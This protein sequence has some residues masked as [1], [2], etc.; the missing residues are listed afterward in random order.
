MQVSVGVAYRH[1]QVEVKP[2]FEAGPAKVQGPGNPEAKVLPVHIRVSKAQ[3][4]LKLGLEL[5]LNFNIQRSFVVL[6]GTRI[7]RPSFS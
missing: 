5:R 1:G 6:K 4:G 7:A 2:Q 3:L